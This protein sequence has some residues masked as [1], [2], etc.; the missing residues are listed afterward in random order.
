[1]G[2]ARSKLIRSIPMPTLELMKVFIRAHSAPFKNDT[3]MPWVVD[4]PYRAIH[5]VSTFKLRIQSSVL[6]SSVSLFALI[7]FSK[8]TGGQN[9]GKG[10]SVFLVF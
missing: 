2:V 3:E 7:S 9:Y 10:K 1:M 5:S 8:V 4:E 6:A